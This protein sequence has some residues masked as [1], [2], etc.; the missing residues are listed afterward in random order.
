MKRILLSGSLVLSLLLSACHHKP[1]LSPA[2]SKKLGAFLAGKHYFKLE[3]LVKLYQDSLD[4]GK[5]LYY[6]A[7]L[8]NVFNRNDDCI[9][10]VNKLISAFAAQL[11]D[12][13]QVR[14]RRL[15]S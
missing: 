1:L 4:D 15:Q 14:L 6:A 10:D 3:S 2:A 11:P 5:K 13:V 7:Y 8:D 9:R 12:S